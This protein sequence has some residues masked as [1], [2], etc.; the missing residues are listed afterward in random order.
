MLFLIR[1]INALITIYY[2]LIIARIIVSWIPQLRN[3]GFLRPILDFVFDITEP[4]LA[5]FRRIIPVASFGGVGID[6]SPF[7][8]IITLI[9][10]RQFLTW[11]LLS[12]L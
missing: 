2:W 8:A 7:I 6:F 9:A 1:V 3:I 11:L 4:F 12:V 5:L 10:L